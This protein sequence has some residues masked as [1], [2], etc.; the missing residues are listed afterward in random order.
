MAIAGI[1]ALAWRSVAARAVTIAPAI[2]TIVSAVAL[3]A[4]VAVAPA[5][6]PDR[7]TVSRGYWWWASP[8]SSWIYRIN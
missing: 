5:N 8:G 1:A 4:A 3:T 6:V 7:P 2:V